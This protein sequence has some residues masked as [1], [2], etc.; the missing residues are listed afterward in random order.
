MPWGGGEGLGPDPGHP[1]V[2]L[3]ALRGSPQSE[4]ALLFAGHAL[5]PLGLVESEEGKCK[6]D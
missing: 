5:V 2:Q 1:S 6:Y 3:R 4:L